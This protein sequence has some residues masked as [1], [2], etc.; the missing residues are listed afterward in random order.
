VG[1]PV[2]GQGLPAC[3]QYQ[4]G[5]GNDSFAKV[6]RFAQLILRRQF[7]AKLDEELEIP[8]SFRKINLISQLSVQKMGPITNI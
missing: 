2:K 6:E 5:Y 4:V 3:A 1:P 8:L 7:L